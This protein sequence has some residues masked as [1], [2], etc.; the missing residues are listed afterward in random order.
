MNAHLLINIMS[1]VL[2]YVCF[3]IDG[4][5]VFFDASQDDTLFTGQGDYQFEVYRKMQSLNK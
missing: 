2:K 3:V 5:V 1:Y 4:V